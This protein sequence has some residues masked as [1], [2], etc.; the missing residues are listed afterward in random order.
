MSNV[1]NKRN[2]ST[3]R[4]YTSLGAPDVEE[5]LGRLMAAVAPVAK[6]AGLG[7]DAG[8]RVVINQGTHSMQTV[9]WIQVHILGGEPLGDFVSKWHPCPSSEDGEASSDAAEEDGGDHSNDAVDVMVDSEFGIGD[10]A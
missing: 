1:C 9:P 10:E 5:H 7:G 8:Y 6:V 4:N 3:A 2:F